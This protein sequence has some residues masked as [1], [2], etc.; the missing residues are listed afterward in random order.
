MRDKDYVLG[1]VCSSFFAFLAVLI[2]FAILYFESNGL[3]FL[4]I[5]LILSPIWGFLYFK[6]KSIIGVIYKQLIFYISFTIILVIISYI[7][8][9][10]FSYFNNVIFI[11]NFISMFNKLSSEKADFLTFI[12]SNS[13]YF[14]DI[15]LFITSNFISTVISFIFTLTSKRRIRKKYTKAYKKSIKN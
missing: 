7:T 1:F 6:D 3:I 11:K 12:K 8:I 14:I 4:K 9:T 15:A 5:F 10:A 2:L 13:I